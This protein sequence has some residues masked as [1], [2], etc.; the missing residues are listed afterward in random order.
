MQRI[1]TLLASLAITFGIAFVGSYFTAGSVD[2]WYNTLNKPALNPPSWIFGPVWTLLYALMAIAA[3][4]VYERRN[5]YVPARSLLGVYAIHLVVNALWS[6]AFFG[7]QSPEWAL[8]VIAVL[9][10]MIVYLAFNFYRADRVA[11]WMLAPYLAWVSFASYLN[12]SI[13]LLN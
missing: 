1:L 6:F 9:W 4:R 10:L 3:W 5:S 12:L 11:G 7:Q 13:V 8:A 2:T